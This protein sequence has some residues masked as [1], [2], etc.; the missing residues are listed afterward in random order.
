M[1]VIVA[2]EQNGRRPE[3]AVDDV[4]LVEILHCA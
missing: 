3:V 2:V 1:W 4:L